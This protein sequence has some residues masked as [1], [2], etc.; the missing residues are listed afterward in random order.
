MEKVGS[1]QAVKEANNIGTCELEN[2]SVKK[3]A[4]VCAE[5]SRPLYGRDM[6]KILQLEISET[7]KQLK[8][9]EGEVITTETN[10]EGN[11]VSSVKEEHSLNDDNGVEETD[12]YRTTILANNNDLFS[13]FEYDI[14]TFSLVHHRIELINE[15]AIVYEKRR[16][17]NPNIEDEINSQLREMIKYG[18]PLYDFQTKLETNKE[19]SVHLVIPSILQIYEKLEKLESAYSPEVKFLFNEVNERFGNI[20]DERR[21]DFQQIYAISTFLHPLMQCWLDDCLININIKKQL[22]KYLNENETCSSSSESI[23]LHDSVSED[24]FMA[25][26]RKR[27]LEQLKKH[28]DWEEEVEAFKKDIMPDNENLLAYWKRQKVK[29]PIMFQIFEQI[30]SLPATSAA[31]ERIFSRASY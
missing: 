11:K 9:N 21:D 17:H 1:S 13:Q 2:E 18:I 23:N 16:R 19:P 31:S 28:S 30:V 14:S 20:M 29:F 3:I 27:K 8:S 5:I 6:M 7:S 12:E 10:E 25:K 22:K 26:L 15:E 4:K 24:D